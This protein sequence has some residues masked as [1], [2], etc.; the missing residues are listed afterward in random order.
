MRFKAFG[1]DQM[2]CNDKKQFK[3]YLTCILTYSVSM[4]IRRKGF[5]EDFADGEIQKDRYYSYLG[6]A[7]WHLGAGAK[8]KELE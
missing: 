8:S 2:N 5:G 6:N 4:L 7:K 1:C 3:E